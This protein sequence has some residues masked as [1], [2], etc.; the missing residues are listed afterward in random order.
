MGKAKNRTKN[1]KPPTK[2]AKSRIL[3]GE[4]TLEVEVK[5]DPKQLIEEALEK[6]RSGD[7]VEAKKIAKR[8]LK[9][10]LLD[11]M[12]KTVFSLEMRQRRFIRRLWCVTGRSWRRNYGQRSS[13]K[14]SY[15]RP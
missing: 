3:D 1:K 13:E 14:S 4:S 11:S 12:K 10:K 5:N 9:V 6:Y 7:A 2:A 15:I 8:V